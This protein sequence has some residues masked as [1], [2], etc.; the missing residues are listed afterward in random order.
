MTRE[1]VIGKAGNTNLT[2]GGGYF[3]LSPSELRQLK[4]LSPDTTLGDIL[5]LTMKELPKPIVQ[6]ARQFD[7]YHKSVGKAKPIDIYYAFNF[8]KLELAQ[9]IV[10]ARQPRVIERGRR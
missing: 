9:W 1:A 8:I 6:L 4:A 3:F 5:E 2:F 10:A 7:W